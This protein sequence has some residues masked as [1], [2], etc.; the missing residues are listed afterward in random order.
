MSPAVLPDLVELLLLGEEEPLLLLLGA[1]TVV[2]L[3]EVVVFV[4]VAEAAAVRVALAAAWDTV[5]SLWT[6]VVME[7][8]TP[9]VLLP[10]EGLMST[11]PAAWQHF[12][13]CSDVPPVPDVPLCVRLWAQAAVAPRTVGVTSSRVLKRLLNKASPGCELATTTS[14]A[15]AL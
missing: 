1:V 2:V 8:D 14:C 11:K 10:P 5:P 9:E 15:L 3:E 7:V 4:P 6:P 12:I 13:S